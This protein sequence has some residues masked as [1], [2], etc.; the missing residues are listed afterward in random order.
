MMQSS[1]RAGVARREEELQDESRRCK[2]RDDLDE[3]LGRGGKSYLSLA[4][5]VALRVC[6]ESA[7]YARGAIPLGPTQGERR[8]N[9]GLSDLS[10]VVRS[11]LH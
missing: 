10:Q 4:L 2:V 8:V 5:G 6:G 9:A 11:N 3:L 1:A 7:G